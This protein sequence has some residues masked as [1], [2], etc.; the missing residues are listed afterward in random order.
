MSRWFFSDPEPDPCIA[1]PLRPR[2]RQTQKIQEGLATADV[3]RTDSAVLGR[4]AWWPY[5]WPRPLRKRH[6][7]HQDLGAFARLEEL[8]GRAAYV[9]LSIK[10]GTLA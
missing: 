8:Q 10:C 2:V 9:R 7:D 5:P 4:H 1:V 3:L 6:P